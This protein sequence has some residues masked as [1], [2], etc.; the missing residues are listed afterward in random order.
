MGETEAMGRVRKNIPLPHASQD[1]GGGGGG[2]RF[3]P[4]PQGLC[5]EVNMEQTAPPGLGRKML[6]SGSVRVRV[7]VRACVCAGVR[8]AWVCVCVPALLGM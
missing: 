1:M 4:G 3:R 2:R 8:G 6:S 5:V 7:R